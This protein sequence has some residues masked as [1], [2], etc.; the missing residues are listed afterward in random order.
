MNIKSISNFIQF[1]QGQTH[2][3]VGQL[4]KIHPRCIAILVTD[5]LLLPA[6]CL[7]FLTS[8]IPSD[9]NDSSLFALMYPEIG[10]I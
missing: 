6:S 8:G 7:I 5:S 9:G 4:G 2:L 1:L 10:K 3:D